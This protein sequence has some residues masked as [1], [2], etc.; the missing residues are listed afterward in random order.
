VYHKAPI[1]Q[2]IDNW[3]VWHFD[4]DGEGFAC[5]TC[6]RE[7]PITQLCQDPRPSCLSSRRNTSHR[8]VAGRIVGELTILELVEPQVHRP[9]AGGWEYA[10]HGLLQHLG[11]TASICGVPPLNSD[12]KMLSRFTS[13]FIACTAFG[14]IS[15]TT[16]RTL[17]RLMPPFSLTS[18]NAIRIACWHWFPGQQRR[19]RGRTSCRYD[20][21]VGNAACRGDRSTDDYRG[22]KCD[23][24]SLK[25][26]RSFDTRSRDAR[27]D[28]VP[29][30][31]G[32]GCTS[33]R[34][35][36]LG[37]RALVARRAPSTI[38]ANFAQQIDGWPTR[39]PIPQSVPASTFSRPTNPA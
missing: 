2:H 19:R 11:R 6:R 5:C 17:R 30:L 31:R 9:G 8:N 27:P 4:G 10:R 18:S 32:A 16:N 26:S 7:Q 1:N 38:A 14:T 12:K 3:A 29:P 24:G 35:Q 33:S 37:H 21:G 34:L 13:L 22:C 15:S 28:H 25:L 23:W 39:V 36:V 20:L